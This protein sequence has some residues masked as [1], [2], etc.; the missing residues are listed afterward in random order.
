LLGPAPAH[1]DHGH[2]KSAAKVLSG[3]KP[4]YNLIVGAVG[5]LPVTRT[6]EVIDDGLEDFISPGGTLSEARLM[7]LPTLIMPERGH[8]DPQTAQVGNV[9]GLRREA[10]TYRF[11][12]MRNPGIPEI[13]FDRLETLAGELGISQWD[14]SRTRWSVKR[15]D[16]YGVVF[17]HNLVGMPQ[18]T[19]F[20]LPSAP[21]EPD[22]I[23]VMMPFHAGSNPVW[24]ALQR[25]A[26]AGGWS[27]QR[28]DNIWEHSVLINDIVSL[29]A[30]SKVVI[31]DLTGR[32]ANVF[33]EAGIAHTLGREVVLI[34][35][36]DDDV[37]FDLRHHRYI[38]YLPNGE[39]LTAL[40]SALLP[41]LRTLMDR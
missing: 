19:A 41:R 39:G 10:N 13:P 5:D 7:E 32:N 1:K 27:C 31:C 4:M 17:S 24:E 40:E 3:E 37:P 15:A 34:T 6:G 9:V 26:V 23:A 25:A 20:A 8:G 29:I 16:L 11:H 12:F 35:Q 33:Y 22:Q 18:P 21:P 14:F 36:S 28:A 38:K 2:A 30:R